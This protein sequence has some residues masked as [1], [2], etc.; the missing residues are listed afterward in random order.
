[1]K[2]AFLFA[3]LAALAA[4]QDQ[5]RIMI[6]RIGTEP[7]GVGAMMGGSI[8]GAPYSA[9]IVTENIQTLADGN[10]IVQKNEGAVARDS[11]GRMRHE[12]IVPAIGNLSP[13]IA[14]KLVFINDPVAGTNYSLNMTEKT[15]RK[16]PGVSSTMMFEKMKAAG[17][18]GEIVAVDRLKKAAAE[19]AVNVAHAES[20][21]EFHVT[22]PPPVG[23][24]QIVVTGSA[25]VVR[26]KLAAGDANMKTE[27][28]G[29]KV[30]D[31]VVAEGTRT[32][33]TI[34][35]GEIGNE[36]P[37]EIVSES[38]YS[39]ELKTLI[40]SKR[41]D[42]RS[43]EMIYSLTRISRAEP[44]GSLFAVPAD[45]KQAQEATL[46]RRP[47]SDVLVYKPE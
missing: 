41:S 16:M 34:P 2:I 10:R 25:A 29:T 37:I 4:A 18:G 7:V 42:P 19:K 15:Y 46:M 26:A 17:G 24:E 3:A 30:I 20:A 31:G 39:N 21:T 13:K 43:G 9:T 23:G 33:R 28:L 32:V 40:Y 47:V 11:Q 45:F 8:K 14:P 6:D 5:P 27:S 36:R 22:V 12:A 1:M 35:A 38:W 44:D